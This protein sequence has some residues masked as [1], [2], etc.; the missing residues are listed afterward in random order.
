MLALV[1]LGTFQSMKLTLKFINITYC[2]AVSAV[3]LHEL[4]QRGVNTT[5]IMRSKTVVCSVVFIVIRNVTFLKTFL[6]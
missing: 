5:G 4:N 6:T 2:T 3:N 1:S